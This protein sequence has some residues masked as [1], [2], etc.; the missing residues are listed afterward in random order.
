[1]DNSDNTD[2]ISK[3][4][5]SKIFKKSEKKTFLNKKFKILRNEN[6]LENLTKKFINYIDKIK[7][8]TINLNQIAKEL[9]VKKRRIYDIANV[10]EGIYLILYLF[11]SYYRNWSY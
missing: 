9:K 6:T 5:E 4:G 8:D 3:F 7:D 1:M 2:I 11:F 10:F